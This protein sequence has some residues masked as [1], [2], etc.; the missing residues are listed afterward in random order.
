MCKESEDDEDFLILIKELKRLE[1]I[2]CCYY[3]DVWLDRECVDDRIEMLI[4]KELMAYYRATMD[5]Q[6]KYGLRLKLNISNKL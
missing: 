2:R 3:S 5:R 6:T 4:Q 1:N